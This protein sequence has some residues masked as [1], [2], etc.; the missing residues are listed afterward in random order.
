M[1]QHLIPGGRRV[2]RRA[3]TCPVESVTAIE[4]ASG[5]GVTDETIVSVTMI[6]S[7]VAEA[8]ATPT[9][10]LLR[11]RSSDMS[12]ERHRDVEVVHA[13]RTVGEIV[14]NG[15]TDRM[16][17]RP[18]VMS[19]KDDRVHR[20]PLAA[21]LNH[22]L[23]RRSL[24][25][26]MMHGDGAVGLHRTCANEIRSATACEIETTAGMVGPNASEDDQVVMKEGQQMGV[27]EA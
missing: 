24:L 23:H 17:L 9:L 22:R 14:E 10:L 3:P 25:G 13:R 11:A 7:A 20:L 21:G 8:R 16:R 1:C 4:S 12:L 26:Q 27:V 15:M 19:A 6:A 18:V 2:I 5:G